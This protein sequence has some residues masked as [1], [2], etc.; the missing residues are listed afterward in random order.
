MKTTQKIQRCGQLALCIVP[1]VT[2]LQQ[3]AM[4][5]NVT[6][7]GTMDAGVAFT[8]SGAPGAATA[9]LLGSGILTTSRWGMR[10]V[11]DLGDGL[12]AKFQLEAGLDADTGAAKTYSGNPSTATPAAPGGAP[13]N[14]LFNMRSYVGVEGGFGSVSFGRD[15]TPLY[16]TIVA[17]DALRL[18][19]YGNTQSI[20]LLS[21]TGSDRFARASNAVFYVSPQMGGFIGRAMISFGS[22]ST[23]GAGAPPKDANRMWG[24]QAAYTMGGLVVSGAYQQLALPMVAGAPAAFTGETGTRKDAVIGAKYTFGD[25]SLAAGYFKVKQPTPNSDGS[26]VWLGGTANLG[27]GTILAQIQR[28]RQDAA[29]GTEKTGT[30]F[31]VGYVYPLS[32]RTSLYAT[33]GEVKNS[34]TATFALLS[35]DTVVAPGA[36]GASPKAMA[37]GIRHNF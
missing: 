21:G 3:P 6:L 31:G 11:E 34:A 26:N 10:G 16:W 20:A 17:S 4:A 33:Y 15:Y 22:E 28:L 14:G 13:V 32:I 37:I 18:G 2:G 30:V 27:T 35:S 5:Q 29:T 8:N 24:V 1:I 9:Q 12:K 23:G 25:Y 36:L 7:Y 19:L